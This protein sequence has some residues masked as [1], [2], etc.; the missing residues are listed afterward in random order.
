M[1]G[2][3]VSLLGRFYATLD[4]RPLD[5]FRTSK[6]QALLIYLLLHAL[7]HADQGVGREHAMT[8]LWPEMPRKSAQV[9]LRQTLYHLRQAIPDVD[10]NNGEPVPFILSD[11]QTVR[12]NPAARYELDAASFVSLVKEGDRERLAAAVELYRGDFLADFYL[13]DSSEFETWAA[14]WRGRLRR[15]ALET[16][17][18]LMDGELARRQLR[19]A[20][21]YARRR[22]LSTNCAKAPTGG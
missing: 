4:G 3:E 9:N 13:E 19:E 17:D 5:N 10:D 22:W 14:G 18:Q 8:L 7:E 15:Q 16:L 21:A 6:V 20:A 12:V 2:L 1:S 11:R